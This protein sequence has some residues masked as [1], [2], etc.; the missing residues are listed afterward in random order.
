MQPGAPAR[1]TATSLPA[2]NRSLTGSATAWAG[3]AAIAVVP[4][5]AEMSWVLLF[6][7]SKPPPAR[8]EG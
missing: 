8:R 3:S 2:V 4:S 5:T 6:T 7:R 1:L